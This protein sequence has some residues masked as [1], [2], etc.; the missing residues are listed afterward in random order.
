MTQGFYKNRLADRGIEV[1]IPDTADV[2]VINTVIFEELCIGKINEASRKRFQSII[3]K[4]KEAGAEGI[5]LGCTE[6]GLLIR[7]S[8]VSIPL[9]DTT[10]IHAKRAAQIAMENFVQR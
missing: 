2:D 3:E 6:L 8:A 9:F 1:L 10:V 7:Q 5:I 4:L